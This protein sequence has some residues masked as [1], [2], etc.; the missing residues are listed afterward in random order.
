MI[1]K[2]KKEA[3]TLKCSTLKG[4]AFHSKNVLQ[5]FTQSFEFQQFKF[6]TKK[7]LLLVFQGSLDGSVQDYCSDF[8]SKRFS[9]ISCS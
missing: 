7:F 2:S 8:I 9:A 4:G 1:V 5:F 6:S 3:K